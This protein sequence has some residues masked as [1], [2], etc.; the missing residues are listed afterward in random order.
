MTTV[1]NRPRKSHSTKLTSSQMSLSSMQLI[2]INGS[3]SSF[4]ILVFPLMYRVICSRPQ[5]VRVST[6]GKG[7]TYITSG[8]LDDVLDLIIVRLDSTR[9]GGRVSNC[10]A[11]AGQKGHTMWN[12]LF[13]KRPPCS[14]C[15]FL[16]RAML[17]ARL[18]SS[19]SS[20]T[21]SFRTNGLGSVGGENF[22]L[23]WT[24]Q[25]AEY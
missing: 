4:G 14:S 13:A 10:H 16:D 22:S 17:A 15:N 8:S 23:H 20:L 9:L 11:K 24:Q 18:K 7:E 12:S 21:A 5:S 2:K 6:P 1:S 25:T 19:F 3:W